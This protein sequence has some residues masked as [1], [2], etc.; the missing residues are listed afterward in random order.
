MID[1]ENIEWK[2]IYESLNTKGYAVI[3]ELLTARECEATQV[4]Y[5]DSNLFRSVID[6][7]RY[8]FGRGEYK[9]FNYPLPNLIQ[10]L[11][12]K[13]YGHL[14]LVANEW[15][16]QLGFDIAYPET[17][18]NFLKQCHAH[19]Q[20][21][22]T[23]L[24]LRYEKGGFNTLHQDLYGD[25]FFPFQVVIMLSESGSD[26]NG[27]EFVLVEQLPRAQSRVEAVL[28]RRGD[29]MVFTTNFRPVKGTKGYYRTKMKH[30][31]SEVRSGVRHA[32]GIIFHDAH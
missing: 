13:F 10:T 1:L 26:Y 27:G 12:E 18:D 17:H 29:A 32:M 2:P 7:Q 28:L 11:R 9:Y 8:R 23:P 30:G 15:M 19:D 20:K 16:S 22:P 6:M 3:P 4:F 5:A 24:I 14:S 21:R 31:I 25:V